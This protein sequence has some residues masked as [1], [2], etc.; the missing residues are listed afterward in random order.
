MRTRLS[1]FSSARKDAEQ[2]RSSGL[3]FTSISSKSGKDWLS[4]EYAIS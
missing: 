3:A 2:L 4:T 1:F